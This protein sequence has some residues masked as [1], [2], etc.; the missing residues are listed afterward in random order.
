[1]KKPS[2]LVAPGGGDWLRGVHPRNSLAHY[3]LA[4]VQLGLPRVKLEGRGGGRLGAAAR[5]RVEEADADTL[6][7]W[8]KEVLSARRLEEVF[9]G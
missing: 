4:S 6:L 2:G 1:M 9:E 7:R 5:E 8:G 3:D